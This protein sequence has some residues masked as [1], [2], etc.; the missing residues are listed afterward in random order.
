MDAFTQVEFAQRGPSGDSVGGVSRR[1]VLLVGA[2]GL[3]CMPVLAQSDHNAPI[4]NYSKADRQ[5]KMIAG[6]KREGRVQIYTSM[7]AQDADAISSAFASKY[8]IEAVLVRASSEEIVSRGT[9]EAKTGL[10]KADVFE[11]NGP[12]MEALRTANVLGQFLSPHFKDLVS[13]AVSSHR[14]YAASRYNLYVLGYNTDLVKPDQVPNTLE[15]LLHPRFAGTV[16][17]EG[18][19]TDWFA[20]VIQAMGRQKGEEYFRRLA[21]TKPKVV[22]GHSLL[23]TM[24]AT[25]A[26]AVSPTA[27]NHSV[28]RLSSKGA[29]LRWKALPPVLGRPN[30]VAPARRANSPHAAMLF[31]DYLLS[32]DGQGLIAKRHR[33]P[34]T[35]LVKTVLNSASFDTL[36]PTTSIPDFARLETLWSKLFLSGKKV[37]KDAD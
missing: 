26:L 35:R 22:N 24:L 34:S 33:V 16:G 6:A 31:I 13:G 17:L 28:E 11:T 30:A 9:N 32:P 37:Q 3:T 21:A 7:S 12:D 19:D 20:A 1:D 5:E 4:F 2:A 23:A 14:Q 10:N 18:S 8:E 15:D 27:Y 36:P 29:P 25:G